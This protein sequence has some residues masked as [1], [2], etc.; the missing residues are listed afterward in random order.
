[1]SR[2]KD[3]H[4]AIPVAFWGHPC[5]LK[6][7]LK[8][9]ITPTL[10][11]LRTMLIDTKML[12]PIVLDTYRLVGGEILV[13]HVQVQIVLGDLFQLLRAHHA[14]GVLQE[15]CPAGGEIG[16]CVVEIVGDFFRRGQQHIHHWFHFR[17]ILGDQP[18]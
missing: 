6:Y 17:L 3:I 14:V 2:K 4:V 15:P 7:I 8:S 5:Y 18:R 10:L 16:D 13:G 12:S 11:P 9:L 1:M